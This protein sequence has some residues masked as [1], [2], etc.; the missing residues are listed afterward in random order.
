LAQAVAEALGV[1]PE[2]V[3][4]PPRKEVQH[5]YS[6]HVK[7][8]GVFGESVPVPLEEGVRRMARWARAVGPRKSRSFDCI[9]IRK[10]LPPG[11][12]EQI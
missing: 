9:E 3:Y 10:N 7:C 6:S 11:W 2:I 5:A 8:R 12:L 1:K 4:L